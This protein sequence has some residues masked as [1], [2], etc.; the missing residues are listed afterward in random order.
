MSDGRYLFKM[1][2]GLQPTLE[3]FLKC[4]SY[5]TKTEIKV[6]EIIFGK[7][8]SAAKINISQFYYNPK[9]SGFGKKL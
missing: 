9:T 5:D 4:I 8:D 1:T 7:P 6:P 2:E 3:K